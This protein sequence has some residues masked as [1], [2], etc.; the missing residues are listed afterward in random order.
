MDAL[1]TGRGLPTVLNAANEV[2]VEAFIDRRISFHDIA[3]LV[4]ACCEAALRDGSAAEPATV[5]EASPLT[6]LQEKGRA[7]LLA[8]GEGSGKL[9]LGNRNG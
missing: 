7:T 3:R 2:A 8:R 6:I 4:E 1:R 5:A 9:R